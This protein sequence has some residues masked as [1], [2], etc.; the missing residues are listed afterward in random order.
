MPLV[1]EGHKNQAQ[2]YFQQITWFQPKWQ[3]MAEL[4]L[5]THPAGESHGIEGYGDPT[6]AGSQI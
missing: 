2:P 5:S 4:M 1:E 6:K 3:L